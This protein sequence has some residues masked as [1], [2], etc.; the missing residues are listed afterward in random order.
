MRWEWAQLLVR[1]QVQIVTMC[2]AAIAMRR[3]CSMF[4]D[5]PPVCHELLTFVAQAAQI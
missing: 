5:P 4:V 2:K 1:Y 3:A